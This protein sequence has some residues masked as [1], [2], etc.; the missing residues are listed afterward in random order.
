MKRSELKVKTD[1]LVSE[2]DGDEAEKL[3]SYFMFRLLQSDESKE[4]S[5]G[6]MAEAIIQ[7]DIGNGYMELE[8]LIE[9]EW[10]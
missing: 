2:L 8:E 1:K 7:T 5:L 9:D 10:E 4:E 6:F 3:L